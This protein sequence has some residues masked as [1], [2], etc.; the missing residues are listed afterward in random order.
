MCD[1]HSVSTFLDDRRRKPSGARG[2]RPRGVVVDVRADGHPRPAEESC[3]L[4]SQD[5]ARR[6]REGHSPGSRG[7]RCSALARR[8]VA[9]DRIASEPTCADDVLSARTSRVRHDAARATPSV[10]M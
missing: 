10:L 5:I 6:S 8:Y 9:A 4:S 7:P 2:A 1:N 3:N